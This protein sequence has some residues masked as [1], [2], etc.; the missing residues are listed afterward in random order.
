M[1]VQ[2]DDPTEQSDYDNV[3]L[4]WKKIVNAP[5]WVSYKLGI[6]TSAE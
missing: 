6:I 1:H 5:W 3:T 4:L 2:R